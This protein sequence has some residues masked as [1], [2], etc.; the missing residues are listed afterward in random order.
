MR[1]ASAFQGLPKGDV[2][3]KRT[4]F[5]L[6]LLAIGMTPVAAYA[7][8]GEVSASDITVSGSVGLTSQYRLRGISM[9]DEDIAVQGGITLTHSSGFYVGAW[10]SS[11][12][13]FGTF[14]GSNMELD[15]IAGYSTTV[16][17]TTLDGGLVW[18]FYPGTDGHQYAELYGSVSH[19]I[20]PVKAK[21]GAYYAPKRK[22]IGDE[23]NIY[24]Y[25]DLALP[26][27]DTPVTLK[28]HLGYTNGD[29]AL[30]GPDGHYLDYSVG[31][32]VA[33]KNLTLNVSYVDTDMGG[34][35]ADAFFT[36]PGG[37]R[38]RSI[39]DGAVVA[40]LTATF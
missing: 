33:W 29:S 17:K 14:G 21:V 19:P 11:L 26:I 7:D 6:P 3:M 5:F 12:G 16:G 8:D 4:L 31:A 10:A 35:D 1:F 39:V 34:A 40:S 36:V 2:F 32:D 15:A 37:K 28:A 22:S 25:G 38:G 9:S 24:V 30:A 20:G 13:G 23:D 18:Y 27:K